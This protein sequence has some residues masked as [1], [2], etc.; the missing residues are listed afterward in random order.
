MPRFCFKG[1]LAALSFLMASGVLFIGCNSPAAHDSAKPTAPA[2]T[3][4]PAVVYTCPMHP[5]VSDTKP[6]SCPKCGMTLEPKK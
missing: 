5:E 1:I 2:A 6:G 3:P 4:A